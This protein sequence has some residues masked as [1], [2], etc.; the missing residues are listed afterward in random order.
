MQI[1]KIF[2]AVVF[3]T[4][5]FLCL[6]AL[7]ALACEPDGDNLANG[8]KDP[9]CR[10]V[11]PANRAQQ[12]V[13]V[14]G[15][16]PVVIASA[17]NP[18]VNGGVVNPGSTD[19]VITPGCYLPDGSSPTNALGISEAC[20]PPFLPPRAVKPVTPVPGPTIAA[21]API[22]K[23]QP[24]GDSPFTARTMTGEW[25]TIGPG[26]QIWY[27]INNENNFYLD[28]WMDTYGKQGVSFAVYSPEQLNNLS[29]AT[30]PKG[31]SA[32]IRTDT[33]HDW[34]WKGAQAVGIWHV[35][36]TNTTSTPM[37]YRISNKQATEDRTN[38]R[39]YWEYLPS[40][41]YVYWTACR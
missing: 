18:V 1:K 8:L 6:S 33:T 5:G 4:L 25:E 19:Y 3:F 10:L 2:F 21:T 27:R 39:S 23:T 35:L 28:V 22:T 41:A 40:G 29:V 26:E 30:A 7:P 32:A 38:C 20:P 31:R 9:H 24:K 11:L 37:Q 17:G 36:V 34:W 14:V 13:R 16:G 12:P 15:G